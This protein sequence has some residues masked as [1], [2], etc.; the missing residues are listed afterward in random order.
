M[1]KF[2]NIKH[3]HNRLPVHEAP[4]YIWKN[5]ESH[6]KNRELDEGNFSKFKNI[7]P[8]H[9]PAHTVWDQIEKSFNK[10]SKRTI[11]LLTKKSLSIAASILLLLSGSI[12]VIKNFNSKKPSIY[13]TY[14][15]ESKDNEDFKQNYIIE[16]DDLN[17]LIKNVCNEKPFICETD[18]FIELKKELE[19]LELENLKIEKAYSVNENNQLIKYMHFIEQQKLEIQKKMLQ[20]AINI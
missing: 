20:Y 4:D 7:L 12:I 17:I 11:R 14:K 16:G 10:D 15:I 8:I 5:I 3:L 9:K 19:K 18:M 6:L 13:Y 2:E 1:K